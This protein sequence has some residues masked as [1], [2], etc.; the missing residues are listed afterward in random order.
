MVAVADAACV[1]DGL[2]A[3]L[4]PASVVVAVVVEALV[5]VSVGA[6]V[7]V[8]DSSP[9]LR[10]A[11]GVVSPAG[12]DWPVGVADCALTTATDP[13]GLTTFRSSARISSQAKNLGNLA[14]SVCTRRL[15]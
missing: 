2:G 8:G 14:G 15:K 12:P 4:L 5:A 10:F 13:P 9:S 7:A 1:G 11:D 3:A 6:A